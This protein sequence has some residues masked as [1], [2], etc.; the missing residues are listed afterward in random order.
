MFSI[1]IRYIP[2]GLHAIHLYAP[3]S[4][5]LKISAKAT[6]NRRRSSV[7]ACVCVKGRMEKADWVTFCWGWVSPRLEYFTALSLPP[8]LTLHAI[9]H[10]H[11]HTHTT[12]TTHGNSHNGCIIGTCACQTH[13]VYTCTSCTLHP[14][15][16]ILKHRSERIAWHTAYSHYLTSWLTEA[17]C[18]DKGFKWLR[19]EH[20]QSIS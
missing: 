13:D 15:A 18:N 5:A 9:A 6:T 20:I 16:N 1:F 17:V 3:S 12:Y 4:L 11:T 19:H 7:H 2:I 14:T 8:A 10:T